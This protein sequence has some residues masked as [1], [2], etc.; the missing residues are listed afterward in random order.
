MS[1]VIVSPAFSVEDSAEPKNMERVL[2]TTIAIL[3]QTQE[4]LEQT[5]KQLSKLQA[6][7]KSLQETATT[8]ALTGLKNRRGFDEIFAQEMDRSNRRKSVGGVLVVIDLD[9]F[10]GINDTWGHQAG[11]ACLRLVARTLQKEIRDMDTAARLGGDEFVLILRDA[12]VDRVLGRIQML[13]W[14]LNHLSLAWEGTEIQVRASIGI[15]AY[16]HGDVPQEVFSAADM[17][18]YADKSRPKSFTAQSSGGFISTH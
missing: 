8:D 16:R 9:N 13:I 14:K 17:S 11:D 7:I 1:S 6:E 3:N 10:K 15:K 12:E 2:S 4:E 5:R 18:M